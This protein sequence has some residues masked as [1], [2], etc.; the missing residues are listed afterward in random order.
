MTPFN[1]EGGAK[2]ND[3]E[4]RTYEKMKSKPRDVIENL[5][6]NRPSDNVDFK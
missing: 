3:L 5:E 4:F 2:S 6:E 1:N